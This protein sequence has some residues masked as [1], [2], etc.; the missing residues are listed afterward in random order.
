MTTRSLAML[1][2]IGFGVLFG[3]LAS[4][5][6]AVASYFLILALSSNVHDRS[7][8]AAMTSV[9]VFGPIGALTGFIAGCIF[10]R[11]R[12]APAAAE[13]QPRQQ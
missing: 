1:R 12:L 7:M 2:R 5:V 8:E 10:G 13:G 11:P 6:A 4:V 9:F 3:L